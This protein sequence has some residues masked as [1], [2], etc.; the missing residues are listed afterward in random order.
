MAAM[1]RTKIFP[2]TF[3]LHVALLALVASLLCISPRAEAGL[4]EIYADGYVGGMYGTEPKFCT[5]CYTQTPDGQRGDDFFHDQSGGLLGLRAGVEVLYTDVY[6][7][8]DQ[9]LT[10]HGFSGSTLQAMIGWDLSIGSG[11][12]TGTLGGYGG[13]VF[14][15]PYTPHPP[16]DRSQIATIGVA[17]E[18]QGGAEYNI[19]RYLAVQM[20]ATLGYH[21]MFA[22]SK[23]VELGPGLS[24]ATRTHGFHLMLKAGIRF[25]IGL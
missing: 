7:Q 22:G 4:I 13:M 9:F 12:W 5:S 24:E 18:G 1:R 15:F 25:H 20:I 16:I 19:S 23:A 8:F 3:R 11:K 2:S 10:P 6:L 21:Y 14:G 17:A